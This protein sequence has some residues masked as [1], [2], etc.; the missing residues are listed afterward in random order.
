MHHPLLLSA[1]RTCNWSRPSEYGKGGGGGHALFFMLARGHFCHCF[2]EGQRGREEGRKKYI[3]VKETHRLAASHT[4][5][6]GNR[7]GLE[8]ATLRGYRTT[9]PPSPGRVMTWHFCDD[10]SYILFCF[11]SRLIVNFIS[12]I[13]FAKI[14]ILRSLRGTDCRIWEWLQAKSHKEVS[15]A[16]RKWN[17]ATTFMGLETYC[18]NVTNLHSVPMWLLSLCICLMFQDSS[19]WQSV[20]LLHYFLLENDILWNSWWTFWLLPPFNF[21]K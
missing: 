21:Y 3:N 8:P 9:L 10:L 11:S 14:T 7:M 4:H 1:V 17:M 19:M 16:A 15:T 5:L 6:I 20:S 13:N 12:R 2:L 18:G